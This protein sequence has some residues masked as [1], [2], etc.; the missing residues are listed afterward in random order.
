MPMLSEQDERF[1]RAVEQIAAALEGIHV[2]QR[3]EFERQFPDPQKFREAIVTRIPT[4][5]ERIREALGSST[6]SLKEWLGELGE[7]EIVG[8]REREFLER[9]AQTSKTEETSD[10]SSAT[11]ESSS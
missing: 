3:K 2:T 5:E 7:E 8:R 6:N 4:E 11:V 10:G 9:S 1:V